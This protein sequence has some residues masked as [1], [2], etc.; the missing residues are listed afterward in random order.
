MTE[1]RSEMAL[2]PGRTVSLLGLHRG[3]A[4]AG[5]LRSWDVGDAGL[6]VT[7][8]VGVDRQAVDDLADGRVWLSTDSPGE[9]E[10]GIMI[11]AAAAQAVASDVLRLT[12]VA[13]MV[14]EPRRR[15]VRAEEPAPVTITRG[16]EQREL[17]ALDL[18][19]SGVRVALSARSSLAEGE[20]VQVKVELADGMTVDCAG[21]VIRVDDNADQAV[22]Q[23]TGLRS[24]VGDVIDRY[25]LLRIA[26]D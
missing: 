8:D 7:A 18:S 6:V 12:G 26:G 4:H 17:T 2:K 9:D 20:H 1:A 11:F 22:V 25:V 24:D 16:P 21:T 19:R 3:H 23:F 10:Q 14:S 5:T 13:N 15:A